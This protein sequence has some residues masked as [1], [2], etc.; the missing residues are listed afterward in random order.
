MRVVLA[1]QSPARLRELRSAGLEPEVVVS[2]ADESRVRADSPADLVAALAELK[3][4]VVRRDLD[5]ATPTALIACDTVVEFDGETLGKPAS[6]EAAR[7]IWRRYRGN[8]AIVHTGHRVEVSDGSTWRGLTRSVAGDVWFA[9][10]SDDEI[11]AYVATGE[12][13]RVAGAFTIA[14]LGSAYVERIAGD[15]HSVTGISL[16]TLRLMLAELGVT[17]HELWRR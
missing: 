6:P 12:P 17:W 16:P 2:G 3:A 15:P 10:I 8:R 1:S 5:A 4:S 13:T 14:E 7:D 9:D 11:D